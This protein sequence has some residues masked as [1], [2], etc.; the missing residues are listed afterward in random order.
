[1]ADVIAILNRCI[2]EAS[3]IFLALLD[4]SGM[5]SFYLCMIFLFLLG[6]YIMRPLFGS[7]RGS[8]K[9]RKKSTNSGGGSNG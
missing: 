8:D 5:T 9:A 2:I 4:G 6:K 1:M 7:S 3:N